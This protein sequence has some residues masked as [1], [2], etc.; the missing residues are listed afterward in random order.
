MTKEIGL[1]SKE[2]YKNQFRINNAV[3]F[4]NPANYG[5]EKTLSTL[6]QIVAG[7]QR[8]TFYTVDGA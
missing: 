8:Q 1:L 2:E 4:A 6:T 5:L 3:A 7:V